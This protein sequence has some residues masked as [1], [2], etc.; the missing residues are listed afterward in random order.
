[1][2]FISP[3]WAKECFER[4][5]VLVGTVLQ[6]N[7]LPVRRGPYGEIFALIEVACLSTSSATALHQI[8]EKRH[9]GVLC[10]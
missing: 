8:A 5:T 1:M 7:T 10:R 9:W 4:N 6:I 3:T 2:G